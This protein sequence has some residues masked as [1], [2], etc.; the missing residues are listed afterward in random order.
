MLAINALEGQ[1]SD[2]VDYC[3]EE[4][5]GVE[6]TA[7]AYPGNLDDGFRDRVERHLR[8]VNDVTPL[9]V[10]GPFLDLYVTSPD[11]KIVAVATDRH[12][13][14]L[15][16]AASIGASIY[17]AHLNSIPLIRNQAYQ[18]RFVEVA[19][20]FWLPLADQAQQAGTTIVLE[21]MWEP[22]PALQ[23]QVVEAANHP[24][25]KASF[26]NGH[27]LVFSTRPGAEWI[28]VLGRALAHVHLHDNDG[29]Y[30]QHL[31]VGEGVE[32]WKNLITAWREHAPDSTLV[33]ESDD[34]EV[35]KRSLRALRKLL[36]E[37]GE[38][39]T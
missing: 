15:A 13:Q 4:G 18:E 26:D 36:R 16:A 34:L 2:A 21:N 9:L 35:N 38:E 37:E 5:V 3:L 8:L 39:S 33:V 32:D 6:V 17:V 1:L 27:A 23:R 11:P 7:F 29:T 14:A 12:E 24:S 22:D 19:A 25:L 10:H 30:D 20:E 31:A 28:R